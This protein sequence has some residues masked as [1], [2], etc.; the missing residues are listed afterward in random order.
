MYFYFLSFYSILSY[1]IIITH[2]T[3]FYFF[4]FYFILLTTTIFF[5]IINNWNYTFGIGG[6]IP[7]IL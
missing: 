2:C 6:I 3:L 4:F 7:I 5:S 1:C